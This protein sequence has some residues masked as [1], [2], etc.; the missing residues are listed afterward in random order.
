[1]S[2]SQRKERV[3][4][5]VPQVLG[6]SYDFLAANNKKKKTTDLSDYFILYGVWIFEAICIT[7]PITL[8]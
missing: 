3:M 2:I 8:L 7:S 5:S 1:M 4:I 6:K